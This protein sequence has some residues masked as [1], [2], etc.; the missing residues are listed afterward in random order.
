MAPGSRQIRMAGDM[1]GVQTT[2]SE[3]T[4]SQAILKKTQ[5]SLRRIPLSR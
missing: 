2:P 4:S 5:E 3:L 1:L